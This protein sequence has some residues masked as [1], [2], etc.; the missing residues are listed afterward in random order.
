[1]NSWHSYPKIYA[2]GHR[3]V[4]DLLKGDVIVEEKIDGSQFS[5]GVGSEGV[6][7]I[8]SKN[9]QMVVEAPDKMFQR[10]VDTV[11]LIKYKLTLGWTYRAEFLQ[12]P[13]H[14]ALAYNRI[15]NGHLIIFDINTGYESYLSP[16]DKAKMTK[17]I[18]LECVPVIFEGRIESVDQLLGF[19][20]RES[21]LGGQK[22]EGVVIKP[23]KY[24]QFGTDKKVL[25]AKYVSEAYKEVH[26][27]EWKKSNPSKND[28]VDSLISAH[29]T[30]ARWN[31]AV[32]HLRE[33][34]E[35]EDDPRDIGKLIKEIQ[36]DT[37]NEC[38]QEMK[39]FLWRWAKPKIQRGIIRG[40]P[41][42]YKE[43]LARKA[44]EVMEDTKS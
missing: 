5:F 28:I 33:R 2:V 23:A 36:A 22:I 25:L 11:E 32:L 34:G 29:R 9:K 37:I 16:Q 10:A 8:R 24:D 27:A 1:M 3:A 13:K 20:S 31:K 30:P 41:E 40:F 14:N 18:G 39:D 44:F 19:M 7:H 12:K 42:Y 4:E 43:S 26:R 6:L 21:V 15:P 35:C 17:L 38:E